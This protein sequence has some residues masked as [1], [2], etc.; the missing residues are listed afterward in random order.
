MHE[1]PTPDF[2]VEGTTPTA[3][4][5]SDLEGQDE[6]TAITDG[7]STRIRHA[8]VRKVYAILSI[9]LG[10][11]FGIALCFIL[12]ESM[13]LWIRKYWWVTLIAVGVAFIMTMVLTCVP[14]LA[15]RVPG[16]F[17][18]LTIITLCYSLVIGYAGAV[19]T[20]QAFAIA[21]G[22]TFAVTIGLTIFAIQ[23]KWDF[24]GCGVYLF[25]LLLVL[26]VFGIIAAIVRNRILHI[27]YAAL[28][29]LL[30]SF[31]LVYDTQQI[32]GGKHRKYSYSI[33]D[34]IFA[35]LT[36]YLDIINLFLYILSLTSAA[37][38]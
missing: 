23:T 4:P 36:L 25:V 12:V 29:A 33:D 1:Y 11:T 5:D 9:Q 2:P 15:R 21:A 31:M 6:V 14:S 34:Y 30:F 18:M 13:S 26:F 8:F 17:I 10:V 7:L 19:T 28:G 37:S 20:T 16:N 24:T 38:D 22:I 27:V 32:V 35:A 3:V